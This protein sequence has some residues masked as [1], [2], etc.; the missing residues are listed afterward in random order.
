MSTFKIV[1]DGNGYTGR[2]VGYAPAVESNL[3]IWLY[4]KENPT[5][6]SRNYA[7]GNPVTPTSGVTY[8]SSHVTI[9]TSEYIATTEPHPEEMTTI[10]VVRFPAGQG[11]TAISGIDSTTTG[12]SFFY[13]ESPN[14]V[15]RLEV[16]DEI[17]DKHVA[18]LTNGAEADSWMFVVATQ[19]SSGISV[20]NVRD[21]TEAA[22]PVTDLTIGQ[23]S[24]LI[25]I[26]AAD[27]YAGGVDHA[28]F[29]LYDRALGE[30]EIAAIYRQ[31]SAYLSARNSIDV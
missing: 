4:P 15:L 24:R 10:S 7:D 25:R 31:V 3:K 18:A 20:R 28:F 22:T 6:A 29:A 2:Y 17:G 21:G 23:D 27:V 11:A 1:V 26:G 14:N 19:S 8:S 5:A 12:Y 13:N 30:E 9:P 16:F